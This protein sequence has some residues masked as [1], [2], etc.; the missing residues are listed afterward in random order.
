[1]NLNF[2][3]RHHEAS[4]AVRTLVTDKLQKKLQPFLADGAELHVIL[5]LDAGLQRAELTLVQKDLKTSARAES[6]DMYKSVDQ[7]ITKMRR[8]LRRHK[9]RRTDHR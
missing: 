1:M 2:T 7:A 5:E 4:D 6:E 8:Q 9:E 3:F